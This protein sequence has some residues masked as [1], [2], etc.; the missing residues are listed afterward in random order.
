MLWYGAGPCINR[1]Q[2]TELF[3]ARRF[4]QPSTTI[5]VTVCKFQAHTM[6]IYIYLRHPLYSQTPFK[7]C[8]KLYPPYAGS[9]G[10]TRLRLLLQNSHSVTIRLRPAIDFENRHIDNEFSNCYY[11]YAQFCFSPYICG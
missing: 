9:Y 11:T 8:R 2:Q 6:H 4:L 10:Y 5:T 1:Q 7:H 3:V